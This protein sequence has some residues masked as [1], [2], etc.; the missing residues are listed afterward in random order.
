MTNKPRFTAAER[1]A[2]ADEVIDGRRMVREVAD[3]CGVPRQTVQNWVKSR[4]IE[5][6]VPVPRRKGGLSTPERMA[7]R[8]EKLEK[9][10]AESEARAEKAEARNAV[11]EAMVSRQR[12]AIAA[13]KQTLHLYMDP[14]GF[15]NGPTPA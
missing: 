15:D 3:E 7:A 14:D 6:G 8:Q 4:R 12:S 1:A 2:F 13:L 9:A 11:L 5:R 10:K